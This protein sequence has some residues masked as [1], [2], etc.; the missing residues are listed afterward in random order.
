MTRASLPWNRAHGT[1]QS[2]AV[3]LDGPHGPPGGVPSRPPVCL[4]A[5]R[6][7]RRSCL[8][9][10]SSRQLQMGGSK[11]RGGVP[12]ACAHQE[13]SHPPATP[14]HLFAGRPAHPSISTAIGNGHYP[15]VSLGLYRKSSPPTSPPLGRAPSP[16]NDGSSPSCRPSSPPPPPPPRAGIYVLYSLPASS[17]LPGHPRPPPSAAP[18]PPAPPPARRSGGSGGT[19]CA[20][21]TR[22]SPRG[23]AR[24]WGRSTGHTRPQWRTLWDGGA[25]VAPVEDGSGSAGLPF[26]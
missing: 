18:R 4:Q 23:G 13:A 9:T 5:R 8:H 7:C 22:P 24:S 14:Y 3:L 6:S 17:A 15:T 10:A 12:T 19:R 26:H 21:H 2:P 20:D 25:G 1:T 16:P 11:Q